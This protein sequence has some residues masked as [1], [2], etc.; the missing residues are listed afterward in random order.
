M[1]SSIADALSILSCPVSRIPYRGNAP[2]YVTYQLLGQQ[3]QIYAEGKEAATAV[4]Y[5]ISIFSPGASDMLMLNTKAALEAAG[6]I[7]TVDMETYDADTDIHQAALI[8]ED[9]DLTVEGYTPILPGTPYDGPYA[10]TPATY[11]EQ[12]LATKNKS[13]RE[14]VTVGKIP[15][16]E[17]S[18]TTGGLTLTIGMESLGG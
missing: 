2:A 16:Y 5:A 17:V 9:V 11:R 10:V 14:D 7:V 6:Y 4:Q 12:V 8:A 1:S 15:V 13:M 18:N 3:G